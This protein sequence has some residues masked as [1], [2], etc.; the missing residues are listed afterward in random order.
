MP[1]IVRSSR[2]PSS[3]REDYLKDGA[4]DEQRIPPLRRDEFL[5][6]FCPEAA[7]TAGMEQL[8]AE[9]CASR[10]AEMRRLGTPQTDVAARDGV[11]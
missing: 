6:E 5:A 9:Q 2:S 4:I 11:A 10:L 8:R 7:T 1:G 3:G